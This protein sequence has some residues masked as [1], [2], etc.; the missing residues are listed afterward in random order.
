[1]RETKVLHCPLPVWAALDGGEEVEG[2]KM[3]RN[4]MKL[5]T[6]VVDEGLVLMFERCPLIPGY[7]DPL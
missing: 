4:R 5:L 6:G 1:M 2:G 7:L 3:E